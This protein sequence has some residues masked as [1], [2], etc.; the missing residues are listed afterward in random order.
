MAREDFILSHQSFRN[1]KYPDGRLV[2][3]IPP[4]SRMVKKK[5]KSRRNRKDQN[6]NNEWEFEIVGE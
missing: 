1:G 5:K 4:S 3:D 2:V 6:D